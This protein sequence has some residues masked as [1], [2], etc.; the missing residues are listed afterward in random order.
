[1]RELGNSSNFVRKS[2]NKDFVKFCF[3][4]P[5]GDLSER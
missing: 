5:E 1:M 2:N 4:V 3:I